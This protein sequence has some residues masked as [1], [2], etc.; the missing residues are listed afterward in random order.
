MN[1]FR[2][3]EARYAPDDTFLV[4]DKGNTRNGKE[5]K[6]AAPDS[7]RLECLFF[8]ITEYGILCDDELTQSSSAS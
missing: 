5:A 3:C 1:V 4:N 7:V 2:R 8:H 6:N